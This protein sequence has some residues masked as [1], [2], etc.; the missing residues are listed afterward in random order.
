MA[1]VQETFSRKKGND[2]IKCYNCDNR[3]IFQLDLKGHIKKKH[4]DASVPLIKS[5]SEAEP[6]KK[7]TNPV[8]KCDACDFTA[9]SNDI[10]NKHMENIHSD[11]W[12]VGSK[13]RKKDMYHGIS[14]ENV[15]ISDINM[16]EEVEISL[17]KRRDQKILEKQEREEKLEEERRKKSEETRLLKEK[18]KQRTKKI[19][20][21]K[22]KI[23][24]KPTNVNDNKA[25][26]TPRKIQT[27]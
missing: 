8:S 26:K 17:S 18:N 1:L 3:F 15:N 12:L 20:S 7:K 24:E 2:N 16:E 10:L 23:E 27:N 6:E 21:Q 4:K 22:R 13:R 5:S 14:V 9:E 25:R 11:F 19:N